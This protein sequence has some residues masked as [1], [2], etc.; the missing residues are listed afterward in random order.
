[1]LLAVF[2]VLAMANLRRKETRAKRMGQVRKARFISD[3]VMSKYND[4]Y[5]EA[6]QIFNFLSEK[7]PKK[8]DVRKTEE[9]LRMTTEYHSYNEYYS[10]LKCTTRNCTT[11]KTTP[12]NENNMVLN[13][14]LMSR[15]ET[16]RKQ[17]EIPSVDLPQAEIPPVDLPQAE[18]P[19]VDLPQAE[20]PPVDLPQAEIP[21][22]DLPQAEI[23]N[24]MYEGLIEELRN[25]PDLKRIFDDDFPY[26]ETR[27]EEVETHLEEADNETQ[28]SNDDMWDA[29][30]ISNQQ[31]PL[32]LELS[33]LGF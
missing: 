3:Y 10:R 29:F 1:M 26:V 19:P 14:T 28:H 22:V 20:I 5:T 7:N 6:E 16:S 21:P 30:D 9:F 12:T 8:K 31:T 18:I 13:I 27:Q 25:D 17:H 32:E 23:P 11:P 33:R 24:D 15:E 4:I 2:F